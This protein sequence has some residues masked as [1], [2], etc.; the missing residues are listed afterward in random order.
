MQDASNEASIIC[1]VTSPGS[2]LPKRHRVSRKNGIGDSGAAFEPH[3]MQPNG[4]LQFS[5]QQQVDQQLLQGSNLD[6]STSALP[7]AT[8]A[9]PAQLISSPPILGRT[10][11]SAAKGQQCKLNKQMIRF[12]T[13]LTP[14]KLLA[15]VIGAWVVKINFMICTTTIRYICSMHLKLPMNT[16][17]STIF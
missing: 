12:W 7:T 6:L 11:V 14:V 15:T 13:S 1:A 3:A 5:D 9:D 17:C 4:M 2:S 10:S 8:H 16:T